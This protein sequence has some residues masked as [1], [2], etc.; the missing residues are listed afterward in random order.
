APQ[1]P[2]R[3]PRRPRPRPC[4]GP[5]CAY[6]RPGPGMSG[7]PAD[8]PTAIAGPAAPGGTDS[9]S[10]PG[11]CAAGLFS[12]LAG[13]VVGALVLGV[14]GVALDPEPLPLVPLAGR[15]Q[16]HPQI[17]VLDRL[18]LL[19]LPAVAFPARQP[20]R[21]AL[22][23][24]H[25]VG[26]QVHAVWTGQALQPP[27]RGHDLHAVVRGGWLTAMHLSPVAPV[28][29]NGTPPARAR[30]G[31]ARAVGEDLDRALPPFGRSLVGSALVTHL[32]AL[33]VD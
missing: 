18:L 30:I 10:L 24:V 14:A 22:P 4:T 13:E 17:D 2:R 16:P 33:P 21:D 12:A 23:Q 1:T 5:C 25:A 28:A 7:A 32:P 15:I 3:C 19:G 31:C 9:R 29:E 26:E 27:D 6:A 11:A 20:L 8:R